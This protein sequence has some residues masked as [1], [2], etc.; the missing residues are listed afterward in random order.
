MNV[1]DAFL[2]SA[3]EYL[4]LPVVTCFVLSG[5]LQVGD[6]SQAPAKLERSLSAAM[7]VVAA[8]K[9]A[10]DLAL[11]DSDLL[12]LSVPA[13]LLIVELFE[14]TEAVLLLPERVRAGAMA[15]LRQS[16]PSQIHVNKI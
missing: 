15:K 3:A 4:G 14:Q 8:S 2:R 9:F 6:F 11:C 13:Q 5:R 12:E 1:A 7:G 16:V 10:R